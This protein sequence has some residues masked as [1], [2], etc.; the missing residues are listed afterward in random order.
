MLTTTPDVTADAAAHR[1]ADRRVDLLQSR[2]PTPLTTATRD[3][4]WRKAYAMALAAET[5]RA[6]RRP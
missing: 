5:A 3:H 1:Y 4:V 6:A 2:C